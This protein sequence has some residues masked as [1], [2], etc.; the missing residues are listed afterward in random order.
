MKKVLYI[1]LILVV[2]ALA[3]CSGDTTSK[4]TTNNTKEKIESK[5][6]NLYTA[7]HYDVDDQLYAKFE[8]ETGIKVNVIK[9]EA[10]E[11]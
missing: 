8:K 11:L 3:A 4:V 7:R 10:D 9:G 5:E 6:V 2:V 1:V